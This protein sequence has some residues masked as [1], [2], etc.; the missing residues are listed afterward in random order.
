M[1]FYNRKLKTKKHTK[2]KKKTKQTKQLS[3]LC[4]IFE[5]YQNFK[6]K[7]KFPQVIFYKLLISKLK[8]LNYKIILIGENHKQQI[9][10]ISQKQ[11]IDLILIMDDYY[12]FLPYGVSKMSNY[13][14]SENYQFF[15]QLYKNGTIIYPPPAFNIYTN[16]KSYLLDLHRKPEFVIPKSKVFQYPKH[17]IAEIQEFINKHIDDVLIYVIKPGYSANM[18]NMFYVVSDNYNTSDKSSYMSLLKTIPKDKI[19]SSNNLQPVETLYNSYLKQHKLDIIINVEPF[20]PIVFNRNNEYRCWFVN[21]KFIGHF[22]FGINK[23][24]GKISKLHNNLLYNPNN[25]L[26]NKIVQFAN[27]LYKY[28][29]D[30]IRKLGLKKN[31]DPIALRL[32]ISYVEVSPNDLENSFKYDGRNIRL[33]CNEIENIDGTYYFNLPI[34]NKNTRKNNNTLDF[35]HKLVNSIINYV[36]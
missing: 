22:C 15:Y 30:H 20:N 26:H 32:D 16:S 21:G 14:L 27:K 1:V 10:F 36:K 13:N 28:I 3:K 29:L 34:Y 6:L 17:S 24:D 33:Y 23:E 9:E 8:S 2:K 31:V 4:I 25:Y 35:Q 7:D 18:D 12:M 5:N 11:F 19:I